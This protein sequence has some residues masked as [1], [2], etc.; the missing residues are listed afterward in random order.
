MAVTITGKHGFIGS[1]LAT[2]NL[3]DAF[4][5]FGSP[6]SDVF[7][8]EDISMSMRETID[9]FISVLDRCKRTGE[10]LVY[11]S[12]ATVINKNTPYARCKSILEELH[13]AYGIPALGLRIAA[14]YGPEEGRKYVAGYSSVIYQWCYEMKRG[15]PPVI[16][17]DGTQ[18]RDFIYINDIVDAIVE[19]ASIRYTGIVPVGTGINTSFN[20]VVAMINKILGTDI[21]PTYINKPARYVEETVVGGIP[22]KHSLE[23]GLKIMLEQ[24]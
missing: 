21:K 6:S 16:Y 9:G 10:Y 11:P 8:Q 12:S 17:G 22:V 18:T 13:M 15:M 2:R 20:E 4:F 3:P 1:E 23:E 24:I 19:L 14:G 5:F 7:F